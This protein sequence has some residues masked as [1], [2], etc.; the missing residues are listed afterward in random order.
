MHAR[1]PGQP[2]DPHLLGDQATRRFGG[3][4]QCETSV[5]CRSD[6]VAL[7]PVLIERH[8]D[9]IV[10]D[11]IVEH[12][13]QRWDRC[14]RFASLPIGRC[15]KRARNRRG[16]PQDGVAQDQI[17][18][19]RDPN[20]VAEEKRIGFR[21]G[22]HDPSRSI[23]ILDRTNPS[24]EIIGAQK[25]AVLLSVFHVEF[26]RRVLPRPDGDQRDASLDA[27]RRCRHRRRAQAP[28]MRARTP[29]CARGC[30]RIRDMRPRGRR[31]RDG[32][33][34]GR[35]WGAGCGSLRRCRE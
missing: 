16:V 18:A 28:L 26:D 23:G 15:R 8:G 24:G 33:R 35:C 25:R 5:R 17:M 19:A 12:V 22:A 1:V 13:E 21:G 6:H 7:R 10:I 31:P 11:D 29:R 4:Q 3:A 34:S 2:C 30:S 20:S 9:R 32:C 14:G 27:R